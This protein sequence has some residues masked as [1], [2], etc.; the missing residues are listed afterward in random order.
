LRVALLLED[1]HPL[2]LG[3][4]VLVRGAVRLVSVLPVWVPLLS[5]LLEVLVW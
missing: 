4:Q 3:R 1:P 2:V 5:A